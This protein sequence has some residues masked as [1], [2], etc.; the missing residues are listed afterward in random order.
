MFLAK[1]VRTHMDIAWAWFE[2]HGGYWI[3]D[4]HRQSGHL[5]HD[6]RTNKHLHTSTYPH[7]VHTTV[8]TSTTHPQTCMQVAAHA[9]IRK[10]GKSTKKLKITGRTEATCTVERSFGPSPS[11]PSP[12]PSPS[13]SSSSSPSPAG[14][15]LSNHSPSRS[16]HLWLQ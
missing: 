1:V 3:R 4:T 13:P 12:S 8:H 2:A 5:G 7:V 14:A 16:L 6:P 9:N 10:G 15:F 11:S